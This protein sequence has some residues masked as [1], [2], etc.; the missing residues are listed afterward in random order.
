MTDNDNVKQAEIDRV[1]A[2]VSVIAKL[3][4]VS[5][6]LDESKLQ[7]LLAGAGDQSAGE[8][9]DRSYRRKT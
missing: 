4:N 7:A 1:R 9:A 6:E 8:H 5:F 2:E 3:M